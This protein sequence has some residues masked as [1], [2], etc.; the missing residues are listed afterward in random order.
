MKNLPIGIQSFLELIKGEP[1]QCEKLT[2]I[3]VNFSTEA[4]GIDEWWKSA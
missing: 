3:G 2:G 4:K 1:K